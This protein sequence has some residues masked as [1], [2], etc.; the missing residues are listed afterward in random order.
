MKK[1]IEEKLKV[2][3]EFCVVDTRNEA[4]I[5]ERLE[6]AVAERPDMHFDLVLDRTARRM[7]NEKL[8]E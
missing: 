3:K 4:T 5:R 2:L 8:G 6:K 1:A 7:I